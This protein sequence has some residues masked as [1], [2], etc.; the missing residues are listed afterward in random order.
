MRNSGISGLGNTCEIILEVLKGV[1][2]MMATQ[3]RKQITIMGRDET[4]YPPTGGRK[5]NRKMAM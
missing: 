4:E 2:T 5:P 3:S 1:M